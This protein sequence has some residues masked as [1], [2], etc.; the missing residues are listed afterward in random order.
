MKY[1]TT[2]F[3]NG[4]NTNTNTHTGT[5]TWNS[6]LTCLGGGRNSLALQCD[7]TFAVSVSLFL[8]I[9]HDIRTTIALRISLS[10]VRLSLS[11]FS[12][13]LLLCE[14]CNVRHTCAS[15]QNRILAL[16]KFNQSCSTS[17]GYDGHRTHVHPLYYRHGCLRTSHCLYC[18]S[19][20]RRI[21]H[22]PQKLG[23]KGLMSQ[24]RMFVFACYVLQL[25][26]FTLAFRVYRIES[27]LLHAAG[28]VAEQH[29]APIT[30]TPRYTR[31][32]YDDMVAANERWARCALQQQTDPTLVCGIPL[33]LFPP[34]PSFIQRSGLDTEYNFGLSVF[35]VLEGSFVGLAAAIIFGFTKENFKRWKRF[36]KTVVIRCWS[37]LRSLAPE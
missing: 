26:I 18:L 33:R 37:S 15:G 2:Q 20:S 23:K 19:C 3:R 29:A 31:E 12:F 11:L 32:V 27:F 14:I 7:G 10:G 22:F 4:A 16:H 25:L 36:F 28:C 13:D 21:P 30:L 24:L 8:C 6:L 5:C 35:V 17:V 1:D 34:L 9:S